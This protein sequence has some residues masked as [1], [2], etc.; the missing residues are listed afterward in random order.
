MR[1]ST[2]IIAIVHYCYANDVPLILLLL[3]VPIV[4]I[5]LMPVILIQRYRAGKARRQARPWV[6]TLNLA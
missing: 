4:V 1:S 2:R 5:A 3:L 6:A